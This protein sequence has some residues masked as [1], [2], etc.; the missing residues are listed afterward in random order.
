MSHDTGEKKFLQQKEH[1]TLITSHSK[2][3][4]KVVE[5]LKKTFG[6]VSS[7]IEGTF[8]PKLTPSFKEII[9]MK[10]KTSAHPNFTSFLSQPLAN[11]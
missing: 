10:S 6:I 11:K 7:F 2:E 3:S 4:S 1:R 9:K 8:E 5:Y